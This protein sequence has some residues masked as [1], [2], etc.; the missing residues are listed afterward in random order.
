MSI[1]IGGLAIGDAVV[2]SHNI[3]RETVAFAKCIYKEA[4]ECLGFEQGSL[5]LAH[6][7]DSEVCLPLSADLPD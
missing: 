5:L 4:R 7:N 6:E 1:E 3:G 2:T